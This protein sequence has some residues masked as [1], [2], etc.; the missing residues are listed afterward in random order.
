M[1]RRAHG[2]RWAPALMLIAAC[3]VTETGNPPFAAQMALTAETTAPERYSL[4]PGGTDVIVDQ[5]WVGVGDLRFVRAA[6]CDAPG[7]TEIDVPAPGNLE[8]VS[9]PTLVPFDIAGDD[10]CRVRVPL[11]RAQAPLPAG[12][13]AELEDHSI[14]VTGSRADGTPFL[15]ATR[16]NRE[17]DVRS[18]GAPFPLSEARRSVLLAFDVAT[19]L[20]GVDLASADVSADGRVIVDDA[21]N[22]ALLDLFEDNVGVALRLFR[23][24]DG[25]GQLDPEDRAELLA[26]GAP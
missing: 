15:I 21:N 22:D 11:E 6:V 5:V 26:E 12:A 18:R 13:P 3:S 1:R 25:D 24:G 19:W 4:G 10:Y 23:D 14:V 16:I 8:L 17:A 9:E 20:G 7:A 2:L